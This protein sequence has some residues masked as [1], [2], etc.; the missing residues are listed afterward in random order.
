VRQDAQFGAGSAEKLLGALPVVAGFSSRLRI[1]DI[2]D[3]ACPARDLAGLIHG[4]VIEALTANR[5]T[6]PSPLVHV[7]SWARDWA[8]GETLGVEL[9]LLSDDRIGRALDAIAP[10][11]DQIAGSAAVA[12]IGELGIEVT[13]L[14]WDMTSISVHGDYAGN[15]EGFP[16]VR[17]GHPK[18]RRPDLVQAR[19]T[20]SGD[21]GIPVLHRAFDGGADEVGQVIAV[22]K[23]LQ[24]M[25]TQHRLLIIGDS[26]LISYANLAAMDS[27]G[28]TF[29]APASKT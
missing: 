2:V 24:Q 28:V 23:A 3:G 13:R 20:V 10:H 19:I 18:D 15:E 17:F 14:H 9:G 1:R 4:Q 12:A 27:N 29:V 8:V 16:A 5:L 6:S 11:L 21:A 25:A 26:R 22:I 7:Q